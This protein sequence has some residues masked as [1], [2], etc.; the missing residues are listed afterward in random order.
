MTVVIGLVFKYFYF[1]MNRRG[2]KA[3]NRVFQLVVGL[4]VKQQLNRLV[5]VQRKNADKRMGVNGVVTAA[6]HHS[7]RKL[8]QRFKNFN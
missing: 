1:S 6:N 2:G 8:R 4:S 5:D 3:G 7:I